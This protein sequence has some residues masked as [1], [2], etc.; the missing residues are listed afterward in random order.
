MSLKALRWLI[1]S[2]FIVALVTPVQ[3]QSIKIGFAWAGSSGM[4][5]RVTA[6]FDER[7]KEIGS[8]I[9][10]EYHKN[11]PDIDTL[12][13]VVA[14]Y[15]KT[16]NGMVI[17]RSNGATYLARHAPAIP[18]FI[19]GCNH[20]GELGTIQN[21]NAPEGSITGVTY[22]LPVETQ[23]DVFTAILPQM[24]S[25]VLLAD[26]R[27]PS[28]EVDL[29]ET[30]A[31]CRKLK[32]Q[33]VFEMSAGRAETLAAVKK[34]SATTDAFAIG[35]QAEVMDLTEQIVELAGTVPVVSYSSI[36]VM[37]GALGGFVADDVKLG[38]LLAETVVEVLI[39]RKPI[40]SVP[41]KVDPN[42]RFFLNA[43]T[44]EKLGLEIPY[45]VLEMAEIVQ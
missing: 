27:N 8:T 7:I 3:A 11:L 6:G 5:D 16:K 17:L 14:Q 40:R 24:K 15:Q 4:A 42:P 38:R 21:L 43:K 22:F 45:T 1:A 9:E 29:S 18:T 37:K 19:G 23:F 10:I 33:C 12:S 20:P 2:L 35:N 13:R 34:H 36:P 32:L 26:K 30:Q 39:D 31:I 44:A 28:A 41:V 25:L